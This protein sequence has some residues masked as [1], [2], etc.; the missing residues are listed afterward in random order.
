MNCDWVRQNAFLYAYDELAD[1]QRFEFEQHVGRCASC[2][3]ETKALQSLR[4]VMSS[5]PLLEPSPSLLADSRMKLQEALEITQQ[6]RGWK[7]WFF[8]P[9][10]MMR[11]MK[12]SPALAAVILMV[13]FVG[14]AGVA[15]RMAS[16]RSGS[17]GTA[18]P[19][20]ASTPTEASIA[21]IREIQQDPNSN[22]VS[23]KYD[24]LMP[25]TAEGDI[26]DPKVQQLLLYAARNN[27][28]TGVRLNSV[29][30]LTKQPED[31]KVRE[32]LE[33]SLRYDPNPG[34]RMKAL[35]AL[36]PYVK[37][38]STVRDVVLEV[39]LHDTNSGVRSLALQ[40]VQPVRADSAVRME[41]QYLADKDKDQAIK[42]Q[43]QAMLATMPEI[44]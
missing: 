29:D 13:G 32:A 44:D 19:I 12:F 23:I 39:L 7:R 18:T 35:E 10:A 22:K 26:N 9:F 34:V 36:T 28:N 17:G 20:V 21:G 5:A 4:N 43:A 41:L 16:S 11:T 33:A 38:D 25:Q 8:D 1:D 37:D 24:T 31:A 40:T 2:A 30:L 15:W 42:R 3:E 14:G 6:E 27:T